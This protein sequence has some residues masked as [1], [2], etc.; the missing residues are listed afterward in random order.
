MVSTTQ[1]FVMKTNS[2]IFQN[3]P[4]NCY[5]LIAIRYPFA[6]SSA[7]PLEKLPEKKNSFGARKGEI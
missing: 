7:Q 6:I 1:R 2:H 5:V 4:P 3:L